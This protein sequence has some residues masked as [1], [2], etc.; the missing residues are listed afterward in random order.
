MQSKIDG[1]IFGRIPCNEVAINSN[2]E[3]TRIAIIVPGI[4]FCPAKIAA[5]A[6]QPLLELMFGTKEEILK[7]RI[8]PAKQ[9]K[10]V[11]ITQEE[12][13]KVSVCFFMF[14][15]SFGVE[16]TTLKHNPSFV[17]LKKKKLAIANP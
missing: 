8:I 4:F 16:P 2:I 14:V 17:Y 13:L 3:N 11:E 10:K 12:I 5:R 7:T 6:I 1:G 9:E 15:I